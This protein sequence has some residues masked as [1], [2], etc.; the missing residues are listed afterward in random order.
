MKD[1]N[2]LL[3][4]PTVVT[5]IL[6]GPELMLAGVIQVI[7]VSLTTLKDVAFNPPNV[8]TLAPVKALPL[9]VTDVPPIV[10]PN[11]GKIPVII[12]GVI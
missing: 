3:A 7:I 4:P 12:G 9:I 2:V 5:I 11:N 10:L 1:E 8:T 6:T